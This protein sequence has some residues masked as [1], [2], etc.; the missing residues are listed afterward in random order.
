M[1]Y[2]MNDAHEQ[3]CVEVIKYVEMKTRLGGYEKQWGREIH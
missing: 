3:Q 1:I 2:Y